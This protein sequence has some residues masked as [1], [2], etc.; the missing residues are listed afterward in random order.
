MSGSTMAPA[1]V[2]FEQ[3]VVRVVVQ[4]TA[5]L[6]N[7]PQHTKVIEDLK[8]TAPSLIASKA[9]DVHEVV[10]TVRKD[11]Y[12]WTPELERAVRAEV[13][14]HRSPSAAEVRLTVKE[15]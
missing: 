7:S 3:E 9:C 6:K 2:S 8:A 15:I 12:L 1:I 13:K 4:T 5:L 10:V 11:N 14:T